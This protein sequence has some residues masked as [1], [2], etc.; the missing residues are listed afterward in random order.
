[1]QFCASGLP[2]QVAIT[3]PGDNSVDILTNDVGIVALSDDAGEVHGYNLVVGGGMGR[4]ARCGSML[5]CFARAGR[6]GCVCLFQASPTLPT[7]LA[8]DH[9]PLQPLDRSGQGNLGFFGAAIGMLNLLAV[10]VPNG[11]WLAPSGRCSCPA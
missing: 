2:A 10:A 9:L 5:L 11:G 3:V 1:M 8:Q 7:G 6:H 4:T